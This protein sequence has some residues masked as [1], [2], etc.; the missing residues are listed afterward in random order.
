MLGSFRKAGI[1]AAD[2][3]ARNGTGATAVRQIACLSGE[4]VHEV[5]IMRV[6]LKVISSSVRKYSRVHDVS[7]SHTPS[8]EARLRKHGLQKPIVPDL[9]IAAANAPTSNQRTG[10]Q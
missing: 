7:F 4:M 10:W 5:K 2:E 1:N 8:I 6:L 3:I 9:D